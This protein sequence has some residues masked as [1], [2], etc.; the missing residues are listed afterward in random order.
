MAEVTFDDL[1][2]ELHWHSETVSKGVRAT[3]FGTIAAIWAIYTAD[4]IA[5]DEQTIFGL[6][7]GVFTKWAFVLASGALL[8]DI[9][10]YCCALWMYNIGINKCQSREASG[11]EFEFQYTR[12]YLGWFGAFLY[13]FSYWIYPAKLV[14]AIGGGFCFVFFAFAISTG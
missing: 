7:S 12:K 13:H 8:A 5:I 6:R 10:Q 9:L 3:A 1:T 14:M 2:R 11:E 4:G